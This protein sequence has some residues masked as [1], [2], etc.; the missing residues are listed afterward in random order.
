MQLVIDSDSCVRKATILQSSGYYRLDKASLE[1]AM[2]LRLSVRL[3]QLNLSIKEASASSE[4][5]LVPSIG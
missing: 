3:D 5:L 4:K 2:S 1:F